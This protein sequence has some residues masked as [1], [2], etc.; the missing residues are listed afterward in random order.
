MVHLRKSKK[1][2]K[3][4]D[5]VEVIMEEAEEIDAVIPSTELVAEEN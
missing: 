2:S 5:K 3:K 1:P 4:R